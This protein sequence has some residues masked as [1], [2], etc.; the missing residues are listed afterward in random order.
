MFFSKWP[1][2]YIAV[3]SDVRKLLEENSKLEKEA[4]EE[5]AAA[6]EPTENDGGSSFSL[7]AII[8]RKPPTES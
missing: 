5:E 1:K 8:S 7:F 6:E 4:A 3:L 2:V